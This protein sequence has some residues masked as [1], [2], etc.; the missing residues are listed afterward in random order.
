[1]FFIKFLLIL[2]PM[3]GM[4]AGETTP[5]D[6]AEYCNERFGYCLVYPDEY[7]TEQEVADN[8]DGISVRNAEGTVKVSVTGAYNVMNWNVEE[9]ISL[10]FES[11]ETK[12]MEVALSEILTDD[13]YGWVKVSYNYEIQLFK[14]NLLNDAYVTTLITVPASQAELLEQL[15]D[16]L[17]VSFPV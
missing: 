7:L 9:I 3:L 14:V 17:Q 1:M 6:P 11:L 5:A 15:N 16:S 8:G 10:Y 13:S 4:P 12:P 2:L